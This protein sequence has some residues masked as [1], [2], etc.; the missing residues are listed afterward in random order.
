MRR[1]LQIG[2]RAGVPP[3]MIADHARFIGFVLGIILA[4]IIGWLL[5]I[6][7]GLLLPI[8]A[9]VIAVYVLT[10][11]ADAMGRVP[12]LRL[13]PLVVR[14]LLVLVIFALAIAML[15]LVIAVTVDQMLA[16][17][18]TYRGN[19]EA[20]SAQLAAM[21]GIDKEPTWEDIR[22]ATLD[23][24][25]LRSLTSSFL[26][27]L[28]N[29]GGSVFL[30]V[31]YAAFLMAERGKFAAKLM[32]AFPRGDQ[33]E[34]T[35]ALIIDINRRIGDYLAVKTLINVILGVVSYAIL[36]FMG[37]DFALFWAV[38]IALFNYIPYV[39]SLIGVMFPVV[40]SLAQVGSLGFTL[41]LAALLAG[42]QAYVGN[43]LEPRLIGRQLNLSP[44]V[45]LVA[46]SLWSTLWGLPG[47][48]LA[49][50]MTSML[51]IILAA[52]PDTRFIAVLLAERVEDAPAEPVPPQSGVV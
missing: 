30:V 33:A 21:A 3:A 2:A 6:G 15:G 42:A 32:A 50:P 19:L 10:T 34:R 26:G 11:A 28:T 12:V 38:F 7:K 4:C 16:A 24:L 9:A 14:R 36:W 52:F 43:F 29:L 37:V 25:D 51:A 22:A 17:A 44:F 35:E 39:G 48:I 18:P 46:L 5:V 49:I 31:V 41:A 13:L 45:V 1:A 23:K 47:A 20:M 27:S 8:V 40:L